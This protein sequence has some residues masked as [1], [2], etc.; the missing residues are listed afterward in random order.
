MTK[1]K[2]TSLNKTQGGSYI[3]DPKTGKRKLVAQTK[4]QKVTS[5]DAADMTKTTQ[6]SKQQASKEK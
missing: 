3:K 6:P 2:N 4:Q 1:V 5:L